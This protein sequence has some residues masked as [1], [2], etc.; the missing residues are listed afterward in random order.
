VGFG[1]G[2][3]NGVAAAALLTHPQGNGTDGKVTRVFG[4][5]FLGLAIPWLI[6]GVAASIADRKTTVS[7]DDGRQLARAAPAFGPLRLTAQG[8]VF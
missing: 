3:G 2:A 8:I 4:D 1:L 6:V 5:V 7:L